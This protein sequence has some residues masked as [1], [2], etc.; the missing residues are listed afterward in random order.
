MAVTRSKPSRPKSSFAE[1]LVLALSKPR[2]K[3]ETKNGV[4]KNNDNWINFLKK[5][6]DQ[7]EEEGRNS[8]KGDGGLAAGLKQVD[9]ERKAGDG[10][11][12]SQLAGAER[13]L[14]E[15]TA[16]LES[17]KRDHSETQRKVDEIV[18]LKEELSKT[19]DKE[20][21]KNL[22]LLTE[23][24]SLKVWKEEALSKMKASAK[25]LSQHTANIE[26]LQE[27]K[28]ELQNVL[29][30]TNLK[31]NKAL[32]DLSV[33]LKKKVF[34]NELLTGDLNQK[35]K[36]INNLREEI[37]HLKSASKPS[38]I[39]TDR[40]QT[41]EPALNTEGSQK[42]RKSFSFKEFLSKKKPRVDLMKGGIKTME[43]APTPAK[44]FVIWSDDNDQ[45]EEQDIIILDESIEEEE[46][47]EEEEN[48]VEDVEVEEE[49]EKEENEEDGEEEK[50]EEKEDTDEEEE[51]LS[52]LPVKSLVEIILDEVL[53]D[54]DYSK[55]KTADD[56]IV[57]SVIDEKKN[58]A[59][60]IS[61]LFD[62]LLNNI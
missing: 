7:L 25:C 18:S 45:E 39:S 55:K 29:E 5:R 54:L 9:R 1:E 17:E 58:N 61:N 15:A 42:K 62:E 53:D 44:S 12:M 30:D 48:V 32:E 34:E 11:L 6:K 59:L 49:E 4:T 3:K 57:V 24:D 22:E 14:K 41:R 20:K 37:N 28:I 50:E 16:A 38:E 21:N 10:A 27:E 60:F 8:L 56:S 51:V 35:D 43:E 47:V 36:I 31:N 26:K 23:L 2:I 52:I 33:S 19:L 40:D 13:G 46:K